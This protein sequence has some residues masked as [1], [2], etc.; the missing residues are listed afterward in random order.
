MLKNI[1]VAIFLIIAF[2]T[3]S[4]SAEAIGFYSKGKVKNS[5]SVDSYEGHFE[6]LFRSRGQIYSTD[7]LL[8]FIAKSSLEIKKLYPD[9]EALQIGDMSARKGG[10][11]KRHQSHQNGL[12]ID[13]VYLRVNKSGQDLA[14]PEWAEDFVSGRNVSKNLD[15]S[16]NWNLFKMLVKSGKVGRIFVDWSTK[17][18]FCKLHGDTQD[19]LEFQTL[20]LMSAAKYHRTHFHLRLLCKDS[21]SRCRKQSPPSNSTRCS[22]LLK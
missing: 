8:D 1:I 19:P 16:R 6:K 12:D 3:K 15:V 5:V 18:E 20:R 7:Y 10:K 11:I 2:T 14:N 17:R 9:V 4:Y 21:Y 13:I 22:E